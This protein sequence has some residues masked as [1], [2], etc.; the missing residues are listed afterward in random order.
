MLIGKA[1]CA[2]AFLIEEFEEYTIAES[3][4]D[5][6]NTQMSGLTEDLHLLATDIRKK[7]EEQLE[8]RLMDLDKYMSKMDRVVTNLETAASNTEK[9]LLEGTNMSS[10]RTYAEA[11]ISPPTHANLQLAAKEGIQAR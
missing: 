10:P 4:R 3:I 1:V 11:L 7:I 2:A 5:T 8:N 6:V 9:T